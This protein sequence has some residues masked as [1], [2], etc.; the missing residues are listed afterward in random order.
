MEGRSILFPAIY[1]DGELLEYERNVF[2]DCSLVSVKGELKKKSWDPVDR[3]FKMMYGLFIGY[4]G[5]EYGTL[6][7]RENDFLDECNGVGDCCNG[8]PGP[9]YRIHVNEFDI[10]FV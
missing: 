5:C 9:G 1:K 2:I 3:C 7:I 6:K 10:E 4:D 8:T